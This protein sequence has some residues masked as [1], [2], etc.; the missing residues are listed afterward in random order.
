MVP[1][2][3]ALLNSDEKL[4]RL[5]VLREKLLRREAQSPQPEPRRRLRN[6]AVQKAVI[7][8]LA[9]SSEPMHSAKVHLAVERLLNVPVSKD[10][11]NSCLSVGAQGPK[12]QFERLGRGRYRLAKP[13]TPCD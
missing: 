9:A 5:N 7:K 13:A 6:G 11:V 2:I 4:A 12:A 8:V 3:G 1:L 10:T